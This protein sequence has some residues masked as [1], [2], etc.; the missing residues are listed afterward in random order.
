MLFSKA[1][2]PWFASFQAGA[3]RADLVAQRRG[4]S[5]GQ[6]VSVELKPEQ[7]RTKPLELFREAKQAV[8]LTQA[9][10]LVAV[11]RGIKAP[12]NIPLAEKLA[13]ASGRRT[14]RVAPHLRRRLAAHGPPDRQLRANRSTATS[15]SAYVVR[16][17]S[18]QAW[19]QAAVIDSST[20]LPSRAARAKASALHGSQSIME[21]NSSESEVYN[22]WDARLAVRRTLDARD[23]GRRA[24]G[25][26]RDRRAVDLRRPGG[27]ARRAAGCS[28]A[29][30]SARSSGASTWSAT[31]RARCSCGT[32][33]AAAGARARAAPL[34]L[35][36]RPRHADAGR[37]RLQRTWSSPRASGSSS[38][39]S[40]SRRRACPTATPAASSSAGCTG[41]PPRCSWCRCSA[42]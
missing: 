15:G 7:I 23:L 40:A 20:G 34:R 35:A 4:E 26:R 18:W 3:F 22:D 28:P 16:S 27:A 38:A 11:G 21:G 32:L 10:I 41:C 31:P 9:P 30:S 14:G 39:R 8:D 12:E 24:S 5:A 2:R 33:A 25:A 42:A 36:R 37:E 19:H 29:R 17:I 13:K 1:R 6:A